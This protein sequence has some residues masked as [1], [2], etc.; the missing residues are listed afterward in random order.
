LATLCLHLNFSDSSL[1][2]SETGSVKNPLEV[3]HFLCILKIHVASQ[4]GFKR[5]DLRFDI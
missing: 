1:Y 2:H 4:K 5:I 3:Y